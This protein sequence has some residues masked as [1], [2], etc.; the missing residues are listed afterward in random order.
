M[1]LPQ[2]NT[3]ALSRDWIETFGGYNHNLKINEAE[4]YDM[5]NMSSDDYPLLASRRKRGK[6]QLTVTGEH[7]VQGM[8]DKDSLWYIDNN[9][10][11]HNNSDT[12]ITLSPQTAERQLISMGSRIV[13]FPDNVYINTILREGEIGYRLAHL[14]N[15]VDSTTTITFT[16]CN[17]DGS[18]I[19]ISA[20]GET[21][22]SPAENL[23]Y[24]VDT[25]GSTVV[26]KQYSATS[27]MWVTVV[28][29]YIKIS[30]ANIGLGFEEGDGVTISGIISDDE[31]LTDLNNTSIIWKRDDDY[32]VVIGVMHTHTEPQQQEASNPI[33]IEREIPKLDFVCESN[34][35]LWGC[36][37]GIQD[38]EIVNEIYASKQ[39]DPTNWA[40]Y[41]GVSTDS[42]RASCGTD[43]Q[44]TGCINFLGYPVFFKENWSHTVYGN[45]PSQFKINQ[46]QLRG[47]QKGCS[48][49]LAIV[50]E[51]LYYKSRSGVMAISGSLPTSV[52]APLGDISYSDA[53]AGSFDN[54]YY[55]SMKDAANVYH[56]FVYDTTKNIW[57]KE[58][59]THATGFCAC[60]NVFY[61]STSN[62]EILE[63]ANPANV[64]ENDIDWYVETGK[65]GLS[66][67]D[68]KYL[69]RLDIRMSL[70][71]GSVVRISVQY[72]GANKWEHLT[73]LTGTKLESFYIP[74]RPKR[75]NYMRMRFEGRGDIKV[76]SI[77]KTTEQGSDK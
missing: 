9:K 22:P 8:I 35:R 38:G 26:L 65:I 50:N 66:Q 31:G 77:C 30:A 43:G 16:P 28:T 52:N 49:S 39:G 60:D 42:Y 45:F 41:A 32:I 33:H 58:D 47:V 64:Y 25:S 14:G 68:R 1:A 44:W 73:T 63:I 36:R 55:I 51:V 34:N 67:P 69:A 15:A 71:L 76:Y 12:G 3:I 5:Q 18:P 27:S 57:H 17:I 62:N 23:Q 13:I 40:V 10:V 72:D 56:L 74:I 20:A 75:C 59:N 7:V 46:T 6:R 70:S 37:Y 61:M 29:P 24:W 2:L 48:K 19:T 53:V 4:F 21:A 54:K 11:Y